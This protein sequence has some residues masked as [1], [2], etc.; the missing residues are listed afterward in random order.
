MLYAVAVWNYGVFL[1]AD[2]PVFL[3]VAAYLALTGF[4]KNFFGARPIDVLRWAAG[5]TLMWASIEKWAYP[6]WSYP[7]FIA[8][9][10]MSMGFT[11]D[12]FMRAAGAVEFALAFA[13]IWTPLVAA[14][15]GRDAGGEFVSAVMEFGKIDLIGHTLIVVAL[16]GILADNGGKQAKLRDSW[17]IA[18]QLWPGR[19]RCSWRSITSARR[20]VRHR[21]TLIDSALIGNATARAPRA[22]SSDGWRTIRRNRRPPERDRRDAGRLLVAGVECEFL[23]IH[24]GVVQQVGVVVDDLDGFAAL[25]ADVAGWNSRPFCEIEYC[26]A[27]PTSVSDRGQHQRRDRDRDRAARV[28]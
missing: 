13:L 15:R 27:A 2:Y 7:L 20:A 12:F 25:D 1:S 18:V 11:P 6:E 28:P 3:G 24:I 5:I 26:G 16:F 8:K 17:I 10:E 14:R 22:A 23:G 4:Q 9:P 19:W 21:Y